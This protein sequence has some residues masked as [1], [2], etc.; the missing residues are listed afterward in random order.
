MTRIEEI[1]ERAHKKLTGLNKFHGYIATK[2]SKHGE[3]VYDAIIQRLYQCE[4]EDI[5]FLL[6][7]L[8]RLRRVISELTEQE[9][10]RIA[11][12]ERLRKENEG[13]RANAMIQEHIIESGGNPLDKD[14]I[15]RLI[16]DKTALE[17]DRDTLR[18]EVEKE[19]RRLIF[20]CADDPCDL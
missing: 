11:E 13:L 16:M 19:I 18:K 5:P 1:Q 2:S 9:G 4:Y 8:T 3:G 14:K 7:E 20:E 17:S 12:I 10:K 6:D 15:V